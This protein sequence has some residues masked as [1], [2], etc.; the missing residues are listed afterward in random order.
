MNAGTDADRCFPIV[1]KL[2][3]HHL[4]MPCVN[5]PKPITLLGGLTSF[6]GAG[7]NYS[8]H[9][10]TTNRVV[11]K[12]GADS[13]TGFHRDDP[14]VAQEQWQD[15]SCTCKS[16]RGYVSACRLPVEQP[17][18][19]QRIISQSQPATRYGHGC[20]DTSSF[21]EGRWGCCNR[22]PAFPRVDEHGDQLTPD[23]HTPWST[24]KISSL[25]ADTLLAD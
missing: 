3:C 6:G 4:G 12:K 22:G 14:P 15:R 7:N 5:P 21:G 24:P 20:P 17:E 2:A 13:G 1:P 10:C 11:S 8:M 19:G 16:R 9:V 18:I 25:S 23:R